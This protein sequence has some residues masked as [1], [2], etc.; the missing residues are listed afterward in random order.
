M[1]KALIV[2]IIIVVY[3]FVNGMTVGGLLWIY[4]PEILAD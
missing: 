2:I 4:I 1:K 3:E